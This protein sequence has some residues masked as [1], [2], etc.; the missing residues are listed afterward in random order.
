M[1]PLQ[2]TAHLCG[3]VMLENVALDGILAY[4]I[5]Q[6][7]NIPPICV[8][9]KIDIEIPIQKEPLNRFHLCSFGQFQKELGSFET[10]HINRRFPAEMAARIGTEKQRN[11]NVSAGLVKTYRIPRQINHLVH[12][13]IDWFLIGDKKEIEKLLLPIKFIGKKRGVG[14]GKVKKWEIIPCETWDGFPLLKNGVPL[15]PLPVDYPGVLAH[16]LAYRVLT[17]PYFEKFR[18]ELCMINPFFS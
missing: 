18:E 1:N 14:N 5:A 8:G 7:D 6:R 2:I 11:I 9:G 15:R 4:A 13:R 10:R 3:H 12:D 16:D 17:Y